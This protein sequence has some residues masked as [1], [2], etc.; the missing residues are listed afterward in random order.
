MARFNFGVDAY[1]E[2]SIRVVTPCP[3]LFGSRPVN[4]GVVMPI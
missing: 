3:Q 2:Q 1:V 4:T